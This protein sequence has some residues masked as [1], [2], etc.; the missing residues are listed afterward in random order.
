MNRITVTI[1]YDPSDQKQN[2]RLTDEL[3]DLVDYVENEVGGTIEISE[4]HDIG[5][6]T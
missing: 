2:E 4:Q 3:D 1:E 6:K 5:G